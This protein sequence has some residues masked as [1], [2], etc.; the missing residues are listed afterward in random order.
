MHAKPHA[1]SQTT[2]TGMSVCPFYLYE[3]V[4][5]IFNIQGQ[6][7]NSVLV[8]NAV[9]VPFHYS[10]VSC[11]G[12]HKPHLCRQLDAATAWGRK[13]SAGPGESGFQRNGIGSVNS[14]LPFFCLDVSQSLD[15]PLQF[16]T[17]LE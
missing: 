16:S 10:L 13:A 12:L 4:F 14:P 11:T 17:H 6:C 7:L 8:P 5:E 3:D 15:T 9:R 1:Q 2:L